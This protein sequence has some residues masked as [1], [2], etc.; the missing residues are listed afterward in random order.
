M[1][2][3]PERVHETWLT[4]TDSN[5]FPSDIRWGP[6][7]LSDTG[8]RFLLGEGVPALSDSQCVPYTLSLGTSGLDGALDGLL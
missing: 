4:S 5:G 1:C 2:H 3:G 7:V 8:A 6:R